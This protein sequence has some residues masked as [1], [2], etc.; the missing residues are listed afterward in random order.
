M[1]VG[2]SHMSFGTI[3]CLMYHL[4]VCVF[5]GPFKTTTISLCMEKGTYW[6]RLWCRTTPESV[7][8]QTGRHPLYLFYMS[9]CVH[10]ILTKY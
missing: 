6:H 10:D 3:S 7:T 4:F 5:A 8:V 2:C 9:K 1:Y